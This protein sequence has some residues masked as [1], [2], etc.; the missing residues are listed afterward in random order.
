MSK[1]QIDQAGKDLIQAEENL[2]LAKER[3]IAL[4]KGD[5]DP[6]HKLKVALQKELEELKQEQ[7]ELLQNELK[8]LQ[9]EG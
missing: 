2:H 3:L 5:Y 6:D 8:E 4:K 9:E 7:K 1:K